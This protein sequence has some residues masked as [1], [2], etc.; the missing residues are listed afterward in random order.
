MSTRDIEPATTGPQSRRELVR[1]VAVFQ[2]KVIVDGFRDLLLV[3]LSLVAGVV[4]LLSGGRKPGTEF[5][6]LLK[7]GRR[8]E[9]WI[10][11]FGAAERLHGPP[12]ADESLGNMDIDRYAARIEEFVV[13]EYRRGG[14]TRQARE[15]LDQAIER[16]QEAARRR[17]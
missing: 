4:S 5:Y 1:D 2:V 3:P 11:L 16:L 10:N 8:S 15:R 13:D 14:L 6:D 7:L 17:R 12:A 9:R